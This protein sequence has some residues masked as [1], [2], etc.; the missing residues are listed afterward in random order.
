MTNFKLKKSRQGRFYI[1]SRWKYVNLWLDG[2]D[3]GTFSKV[4]KEDKGGTKDNIR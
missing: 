2:D 4:S 1:L 3:V